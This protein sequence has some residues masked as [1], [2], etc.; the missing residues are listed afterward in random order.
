MNGDG[1]VGHRQAKPLADKTF[2]SI[3]ATLPGIGGKAG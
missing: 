1:I 2:G 3:A